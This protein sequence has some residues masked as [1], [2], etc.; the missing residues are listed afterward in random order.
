MSSYHHGVKVLELNDGTRPIQTVST[1]IIGTVTTASDADPLVFPLDK[2][3][4][5][6]NPQAALSS[7]GTKG[8]LS[9]V[10]QAIAD[11]TNAAV[12]VVRVQ[13]LDDQTA[14]TSAIVGGNANGS[15][16]GMKALLAAEAQLGVKPR[17]LGVPG[18]DSAAVA[19]SLV[20]IAQQLRAMAYVSA[21]NCQSKEEAV[22]Y[23]QTFGAREVMVIWPRIAR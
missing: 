23:R 7:A 10:L 17:I 20:S 8:T 11:Q 4:L 16:T 15:Y 12:V 1:S 21:Y 14:Q 5:I 13:Q 9:K 18:L 19:T 3:V 2:A 22:A 6:T